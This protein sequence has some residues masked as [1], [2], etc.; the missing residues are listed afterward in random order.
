MMPGY[1]I[2]I[3]DEH[4]SLGGLVVRDGASEEENVRLWR[5]DH[6]VIP[7]PALL[8]AQAPPFRLRHQLS[9]GYQL[10]QFLWQHDV[11]GGEERREKSS[12]G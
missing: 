7:A 1:K 2:S 10:R 9:L 5:V 11:P 4:G 3:A 12:Q 6:V 8:Y